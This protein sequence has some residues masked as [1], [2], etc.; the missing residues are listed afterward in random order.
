M[1]TDR[2]THTFAHTSDAN[3]ALRTSITHIHTHTL[4]YTHLLSAAKVSESMERHAELTCAL[5]Y[6]MLTAPEPAKAAQVCI[7]CVC[8][9]VL[10]CVFVCVCV[11]SE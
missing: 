9:C 3:N 4:T 11:L 2:I 7:L 10:A 8:A 5:I 6:G 1:D